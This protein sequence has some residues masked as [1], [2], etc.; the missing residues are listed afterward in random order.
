LPSLIDR[1]LSGPRHRTDPVAVFADAV[2][3]VIR[4][5]G[6][7]DL[8]VQR[9][10]AAIEERYSDPDWTATRAAAEQDMPPTELSSRFTRATGV[11]W[12]EYRRD[13]RL[14]HAAVLLLTST[15]SIKEVWA[16]V[17][18]NDGSN[19]THDFSRRFGLSPREYRER[20]I[21]RERDP[22]P[23]GEPKGDDSGGSHRLLIIED[24]AGTRETLGKY[25]RLH[26]CSVSTAATAADGLSALEQQAFQAALIDYHLPDMTGLECLR[27]LRRRGNTS[28]AAAI[29]T[30]DWDVEEEASNIRAL[31]GMLASKLCDAEDIGRLV[32]SLFALRGHFG[33]EQ[34]D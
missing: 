1:Y 32:S 30:A 22:P 21:R 23:D 27:E 31:G 14:D 13:V 26:G 10:I 12:T 11:S 15:K 17:G 19:F 33:S 9:A 28:V 18:Y 24:D 20:E 4:Y 6:V 7:G 2:I 8:A 34:A 5:R 16:A 3:D 25:L 29:F